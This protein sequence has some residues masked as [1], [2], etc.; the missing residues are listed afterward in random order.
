M[1]LYLFRPVPADRRAL[2]LSC[3]RRVRISGAG[4]R[5]SDA[6]QTQK[7]AG[8]PLGKLQLRTSLK[9]QPIN[10]WDALRDGATCSEGLW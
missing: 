10:A 9:P 3:R 2:L 4:R 6:S 7:A 5:I 8:F 1:E